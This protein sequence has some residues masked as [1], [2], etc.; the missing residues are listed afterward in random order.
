MGST[1][2]RRPPT[3]VACRRFFTQRILCYRA[4]I[5]QSDRAET[6][7]FCGFAIAIRRRAILS[8]RCNGLVRPASE[9][10]GFGPILTRLDRRPDLLD[11][12]DDKRC[13]RRHPA[14]LQLALSGALRQAL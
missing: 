4:A 8:G 2:E 3:E 1:L 6:G 11:G 10:A 12:R 13:H 5:D 14:D 9:G 7:V